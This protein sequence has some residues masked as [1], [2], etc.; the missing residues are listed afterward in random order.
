[1]NNLKYYVSKLNHE[2]ENEIIQNKN[3]I[4]EGVE[5]MWK[6]KYLKHQEN[7]IFQNNDYI[8]YLLKNNI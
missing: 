3:E 2:F 7:I 5:L 6:N 4:L 1:M 8:L